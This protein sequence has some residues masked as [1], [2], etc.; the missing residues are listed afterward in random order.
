MSQPVAHYQKL[1]AL[2][3]YPDDAYAAAVQETQKFLDETCSEASDE[4]REFTEF[5]SRAT[6]DEIEELYTRSFDVQAITTLDVGYVL[7]GDDY[8]R[9]EL[10]AKLSGEYRT[11]GVDCG[12]ELQDHLPNLLKLLDEMEESELRLEM[13]QKIVG[14]ALRKIIGEFDPKKIEKKS[15]I[16]KKHHRTLIERSEQYGIIYEKPLRA[17]FALFARDFDIEAVD[18]PIVPQQ[19]RFLNSIGTEMRLE[20]NKGKCDGLPG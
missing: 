18:T 13:I 5:V 14:P 3:S 7:F 11:Y 8:K 10:L 2:F 16:Y 19:S 15:A 17:L 20:S 1:A 9:G 4:L 12:T 6:L